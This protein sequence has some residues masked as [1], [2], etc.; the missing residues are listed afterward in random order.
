MDRP[1][2]AAPRGFYGGRRAG[3][4]FRP[5]QH[6]WASLFPLA[7]H[8]ARSI[9]CAC[10]PSIVDFMERALRSSD[11]RLYQAQVSAKF[12]GL[13][14]YEQPMHTDRNH[15]WLPARSDAPLGHVETFLYLS[16]VYEGCAPTHLV[17]IRDSIGRAL[18]GPADHARRRPG[19]LR[20]RA[21]RGRACAA[22]CSRTAP[23]SSIAA[24][25]SPRPG[26][27]GSC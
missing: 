26:A 5:E 25:T 11:L 9:G 18:D 2:A 16:D 8:A 4:G 24:S 21:S 3:P 20:R 6:R 17:S 14:N 15:S 10:I 27:R 1:S 23:M 22:R 7:G 12:T 13:T 19:D